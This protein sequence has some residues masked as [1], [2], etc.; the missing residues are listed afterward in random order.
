MDITK[1][2]VSVAIM[3]GITLFTRLFPFLFYR[4]RDLPPVLTYIQ[5]YIPPIIMTVLVIYCL[6]GV[7][8][9]G[10]PH[11]IPEIVCIVAVAA[12]HLWKRNPLIS[13][14]GG[15]ILYMVL[16]QTGLPAR[17]F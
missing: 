5:R 8:W 17:F 2:A 10:A 11:G 4:N 14:F 12:L 9:V 1:A 7:D 15:T 13:I 16:I 6:H 3:A